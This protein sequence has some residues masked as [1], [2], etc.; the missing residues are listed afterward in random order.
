MNAIQY[1][2]ILPL[3]YIFF[4]FLSPNNFFI[5]LRCRQ[6]TLV[7]ALYCQGRKMF[8]I[9]EIFRLIQASLWMDTFSFGSVTDL[10]P[11]RRL[12]VIHGVDELSLLYQARYC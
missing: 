11:V 6:F 1:I 5:F 12:A 4:Y 7:F 2:R 8:S 10:C 3:K 9:N